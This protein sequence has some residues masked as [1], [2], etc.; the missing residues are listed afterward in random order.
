MKFSIGDPVYVKSNQ[1]EGR[2][3]AFVSGEMAEVEVN[4]KRYV[5]YLS[6]LDHPY[7]N[8][9]LN[10]KK[11]KK[12]LR[13]D[14]LLP[15][16]K[17][18]RSSGLSMGIYLA[19]FPEYRFDG[20]EDVVERIRVF[21]YNETWQ[22]LQI[23][24]TCVVRGES[25]FSLA[26][27]LIPES[28]V[29]VHDIDFE[30]AS[31]NPVFTVQCADLDDPAKQETF[32]F[33]LKGKKLHESLHQLRF[34]N[35]AFFSHCLAQEVKVPPAIRVIKSV[36]I[37]VVPSAK[38]PETH[39]DFEKAQKLA[40]NELDLHASALGLDERRLSSSEI[41]HFQLREARK[42]ID[43]AMAT[44]QS[45][46]IL[47]HGVGKGVLKSELHQALDQ[48]NGVVSYVNEYDSRYGYGATRV[49][50]RY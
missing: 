40:K 13:G 8:W 41:L 26:P 6:D 45:E 22:D 5:V 38:K 1:E 21:L 25:L 32:T 20:M 11:D 33:T 35:Q 15:E 3:V 30:S 43:L 50:F 48:T 23:D 16:S 19:F 18:R 17:G 49:I 36:I 2:L 14:Q 27:R 10:K 46:L 28:E 42:A 44:H 7:L 4:G 9:F 34:K 47:I 37:P 29:Y 39:F 24:Y 12:V 31:Q